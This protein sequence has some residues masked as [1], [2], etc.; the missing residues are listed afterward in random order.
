V[1][2]VRIDT[3]SYLQTLESQG[4]H[5]LCASISHLGHSSL[6][7]LTNDDIKVWSL[8]PIRVT[9]AEKFPGNSGCYINSCDDMALVPTKKKAYI[10]GVKVNER[11]LHHLMETG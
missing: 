5:H 3:M 10:V 6:W 9:K 2:V 1:D 4:T 11:H 7:S 8:Q